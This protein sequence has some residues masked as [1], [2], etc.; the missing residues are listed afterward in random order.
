MKKDE[1]REWVKGDSR[2]PRCVSMLVAM[3]EVINCRLHNIGN[4]MSAD[5]AA[6]WAL[7][8]SHS[9]WKMLQEFFVQTSFFST[10][11]Y[12]LNNFHS[13]HISIAVSLVQPAFVVGQCCDLHTLLVDTTEPVSSSSLTLMNG[14]ERA[15]LLYKLSGETYISFSSITLRN[16][17]CN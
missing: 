16:F 8:H 10:S 12:S 1:V 17:S 4:L 6:I 7:S 5:C 2:V 9:T 13:V 3:I 15:S 11:F 14:G